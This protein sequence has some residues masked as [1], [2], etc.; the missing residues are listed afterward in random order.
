MKN[1]NNL[2][3]GSLRDDQVGVYADYLVK[4]A[5]AY[6]AVAPEQLDARIRARRND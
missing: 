1:N 2:I 4:F 6:G 5:Q 3:G